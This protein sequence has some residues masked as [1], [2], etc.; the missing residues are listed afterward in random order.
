MSATNRGSKRN[1]YDFYATPTDVVENLMK[2]IDLNQYGNRVLEPSA[3]KGNICRVVKRHYPHKN[4]TALEIRDE[5]RDILTQCSD[6]VIIGD[7]LYEDFGIKYDIIIGNPPYT[8]ALE[9]I[10]KSLKIL[11][12]NGILV[13]LLRT[14][15]LESKSRHKFWQSN[16]INRLYV[17]SK[18]PSFT[19]KGT[20]ATSYSWFIWEPSNSN[21]CIK[22][23]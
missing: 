16:P 4:I 17:L 20:D 6:E 5:E 12:K 1:P 18:R 11:E 21:Q 15:F 2:N 3:G 7:F 23:I 9:F 14:A 10:N 8:D 22:V 13:F 19:G